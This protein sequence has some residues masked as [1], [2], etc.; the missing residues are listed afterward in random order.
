MVL[1]DER[2]ARILTQSGDIAR[3]LTQNHLLNPGRVILEVRTAN[4]ALKSELAHQSKQHLIPPL[5]FLTGRGSAISRAGIPVL[6]LRG[7]PR[8]SRG[9]VQLPENSKPRPQ[10]WSYASI[11][12]WILQI[13]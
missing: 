9:V 12:M 8:T 7:R 5:R 2:R 4:A 13:S 1:G 3:S 11:S 6:A 10:R